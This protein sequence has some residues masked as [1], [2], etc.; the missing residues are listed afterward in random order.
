MSIQIRKMTK[1]DCQ[2]V[3]HVT[4]VAWNETYKGIVPN[5]FLDDLYKNEE[6][7]AQN[8]YNKF[9]EKENHKFVLEVDNKVVGF[10]NVG[11]CDDSEYNNCGEIYA[12]Y[13]I[14]KYKGFGY[15][16]M[17]INIGIKELKNMNFDKM[18]IACLVGNPTNSFYEHLGGRL[19][20]QRIFKKLQLPENVYYFDKI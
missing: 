9:N 20:K 8:S 7:R 13:I 4:T 14:N 19:I 18:I 2:S 17:L 3:A 1:N 11:A 15:G 5:N 12:L 10:I 16:K 6:E